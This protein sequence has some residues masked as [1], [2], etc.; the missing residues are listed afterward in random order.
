MKAGSYEA[1][2][3]V[4][5]TFW[6]QLLRFC[7]NRICR[8]FALQV[9]ALVL[10]HVDQQLEVLITV[11]TMRKHAPIITAFIFTSRSMGNWMPKLSESVNA[12]RRSPVHCLLIFPI[13]LTSSIVK[14]CRVTERRETR[15]C[16]AL[17][18]RS[19]PK[20]VCFY[21][22]EMMERFI[23]PSSFVFLPAATVTR[24]LYPRDDFKA[25]KEERGW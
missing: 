7:K 15:A 11:L 18:Q 24:V 22:R 21:W 19:T 1:A 10:W 20:L 13:L 14:I 12:S 5:A 16:V 9:L 4:S 25:A 8:T 17:G 6:I 3:S 2:A 23:I